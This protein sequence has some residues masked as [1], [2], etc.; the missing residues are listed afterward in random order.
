[1]SL[2]LGR[3]AYSLVLMHWMI[4][5]SRDGGTGVVGTIGGLK[6]KQE[7]VTVVNNESLHGVVYM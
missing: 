5:G 7:A 4:L 6:P 1:M 2:P 3:Q